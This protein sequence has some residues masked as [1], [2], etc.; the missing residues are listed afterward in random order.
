MTKT[1]YQIYNIIVV[2]IYMSNFYPIPNSVYGL[3]IG[4]STIDACFVPK[5]QPR[6]LSEKSWNK[7][8]GPCLG[9]HIGGQLLDPLSDSEVL[10]RGS[11]TPKPWGKT[12]MGKAQ[13]KMFGSETVSIVQT[14]ID[15][16][17]QIMQQ[18]VGMLL[19][20][21]L[22]TVFIREP[23][24]CLGR[25]SLD[26][27]L[28]AWLASGDEFLIQ[29]ALEGFDHSNLI[30]ESETD[31]LAL[32]VW[33]QDP[34]GG[35]S[36]VNSRPDAIFF[37]AWTPQGAEA[38]RQLKSLERHPVFNGFPLHEAAIFGNQALR[39]VFFNLVTAILHNDVTTTLVETKVGII[40]APNETVSSLVKKH[41]PQLGKQMISYTLFLYSLTSKTV[42]F[43][44]FLFS[45]THHTNVF[46]NSA[47]T[48]F[49][50]PG[51]QIYTC[52]GWADTFQLGDIV[53]AQWR[54]IAE[55]NAHQNN[56]L[57]L[58]RFLVAREAGNMIHFLA[59]EDGMSNVDRWRLIGEF[60]LHLGSCQNFEALVRIY[61]ALRKAASLGDLNRITVDL[62]NQT[63][64]EDDI[65]YG[66]RQNVQ[67][68]A[69][70]GPVYV[71]II[72]DDIP[73]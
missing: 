14:Q 1:I 34:M 36:S 27:I 15:E 48:T 3:D 30:G 4:D 19:G 70:N 6:S 52:S 63:E 24:F 22:G 46:M 61:L 64:F 62:Q 53:E 68:N 28:E 72:D 45:A 2:S 11:R 50:S 71:N 35:Y 73:W 65:P 21:S 25:P 59:D 29:T 49:G 58:I 38:L 51:T 10:S 16:L 54:N 43:E 55:A 47:S 56:Q 69:A 66:D 33:A 37:D 39:N 60:K 20:G 44:Q 8:V 13:A 17:S 23:Q 42:P 32:G 26:K 57:E 67:E 7:L 41:A 31:R 5:T 9:T 12:G 40:P 18:R